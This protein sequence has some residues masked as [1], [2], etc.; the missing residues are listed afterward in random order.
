MG[1]TESTNERK[2]PPSK[3]LAE[4]STNMGS[5]LNYSLS[6]ERIVR[7]RKGNGIVL[8]AESSMNYLA[9]ENGSNVTLFANAQIANE[10]KSEES[11]L[12]P[13][14]NSLDFFA[15]A[16]FANGLYFLYD[17]GNGIWILDPRAPNDPIKWK[18]HD[19]GDLS[20]GRILRATKDGKALLVGQDGSKIRIIETVKNGSAAKELTLSDI[21]EEIYDHIGIGNDKVA[22]V[23]KSGELK[24]FNFD[25]ATQ[26][27]DLYT[28][29]MV[30]INALHDQY[31][32]TLAVT[33]DAKFIAVGIP[34][35]DAGFHTAKIIVY[36]LDGK[37]LTQRGELDLNHLAYGKCSAMAFV[38]TSIG[39]TTLVVLCDT[40]PESGIKSQILTLNFNRR[41]GF[42]TQIESMRKAVDANNIF[43]LLT[44]GQNDVI[45]IDGDGRFMKIQY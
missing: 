23:F 28:S 2:P 35:E 36:E 29:T 1:C 4:F 27:I 5:M 24:I 40:N 15:D 37:S 42:L 3:F 11:K 39:D 20:M 9:V 8:A 45:G 7:G 30:K 6:G 22:L 12:A 13:I 21:G 38:E 10:F 31:C 32:N 26:K 14:N 33:K 43:M 17:S 44:P 41:S 18:D 34:V 25:L 16:V 19:A